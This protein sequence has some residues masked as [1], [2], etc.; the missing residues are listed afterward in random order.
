MRS[1]LRAVLRGVVAALVPAVIVESELL[2]LPAA[3][4][5]LLA[6]ER[7]TVDIRNRAAGQARSAAGSGRGQRN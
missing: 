4:L 5:V 2:E 1:L 7:D 6:P 3:A